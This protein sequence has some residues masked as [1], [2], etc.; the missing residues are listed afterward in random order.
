MSKFDDLMGTV[1]S[2]FQIGFTG[3]RLKNSSGNLSVRNPADS[4]D[5]EITAS[6]VNISGNAI[7]LNSDAAGAGAD[8]RLSIQRAIAGMTANLTFLWPSNYGTNGQALVSDGTGNMSWA[9]VGNTA[10][11][12]KYDST[13]IAFGTASPVALLTTTATDII[14]RV[15]IV[16]DTAFNG[17]PSLSIGVAGTTSKYGP[18]T[19]ID[20]TQAAG[21]TIQLHPSLAAQGVE[22]L[23]ATYAAGGASAGAARIIV[24]YVSPAL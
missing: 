11:C 19:S 5:A 12:G 23:I 1:L 24:E 4:A 22:N 13:S 7:D 21:T 16:I 14:A 8:W 6:K 9:S 10:I 18:S 3:P 20:L 17:T 15:S 2:Y